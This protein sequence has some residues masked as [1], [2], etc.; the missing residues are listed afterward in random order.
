M[1]H[2]LEP[3]DVERTRWKMALKFTELADKYIDERKY[4]MLRQAMVRRCGNWPEMKVSGSH[5][6]PQNPYNN[7]SNFLSLDREAVNLADA[8][9]WVRSEFI[10]VGPSMLIIRKARSTAAVICPTCIKSKHDTNC[11][12]YARASSTTSESSPVSPPPH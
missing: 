5:G 12:I 4:H 10:S 8:V 11:K 2:D 9:V 7:Q 1:V 6:S 3:S